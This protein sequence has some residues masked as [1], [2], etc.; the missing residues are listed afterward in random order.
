[1]ATAMTMTVTMKD[2]NKTSLQEAKRVG[3]LY[4]TLTLE[5]ICRQVGIN[6]QEMW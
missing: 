3:W 2:H 1:M 6:R 5:V 4:R